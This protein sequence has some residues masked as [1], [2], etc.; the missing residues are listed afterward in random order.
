M[1]AHFSIASDALGRIGTQKLEDN[2][3]HMQDENQEVRN[4]PPAMLGF[5]M[6]NSMETGYARQRE[7][8]KKACE[9]EKDMER[10]IAKRKRA[11]EKVIQEEKEKKARGRGVIYV[12]HIPRGFYK[13]QQYQ[14]FSQ[15][16]KVT[17]VRLAR[18]KKTGA[19]KGYGWVEFDDAAVADEVLL[20]NPQ[21]KALPYLLLLLLLLIALLATFPH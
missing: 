13:E 1:S 14:F 10:K 8:Y 21:P 20:I 4:L 12:G 7:N 5:I 3:F 11:L 2:I 17:R 19:Y 18:N 15:Y 9:A 6:N 16:G